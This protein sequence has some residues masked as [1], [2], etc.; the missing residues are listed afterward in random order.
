MMA[1]ATS[2]GEMHRILNLT[3]LFMQASPLLQ[4]NVLFVLLKKAASC[5][6]NPLLAHR[7]HEVV[8]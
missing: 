5:L 6:L 7:L 8:F 4:L 3:V 1:G 2:E